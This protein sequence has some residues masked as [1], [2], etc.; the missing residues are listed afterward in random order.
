MNADFIECD[1]YKAVRLRFE[2]SHLN[3]VMYCRRRKHCDETN[4]YR[5]VSYRTD[6]FFQK[7]WI[8]QNFECLFIKPI[9]MTFSQC[10]LF[11]AVF[12][13]REMSSKQCSIYYLFSHY[14]W[15]KRWKKFQIIFRAFSVTYFSCL[16]K[17]MSVMNRCWVIIRKFSIFTA[18]QFFGRGR[19]QPKNIEKR[20]KHSF[21]IGR[22]LKR[23]IL[24]KCFLF[25]FRD[26]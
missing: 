7:R 3:H 10:M 22:W 4:R 23:L 20:I 11:E 16:Q 24:N 12:F 25:Y 5:I 1:G 18:F 26:W 15:D 14:D 21:Q 9:L 2:V 8:H 19:S 17:K 13:S 6:F